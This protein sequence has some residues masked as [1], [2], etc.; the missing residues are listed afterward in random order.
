MVKHRFTLFCG[1]LVALLLLPVF[2]FAE[3][4]GFRDVEWGRDFSTFTDLQHLEPLPFSSVI[5]KYIK[6]GPGVKIGDITA[7]NKM[8]GFCQGKL[9][10]FAVMVVGKKDFLAL[11]N[12][13]FEKFGSGDQRVRH[14]E[15]YIR[16]VWPRVT[17]TSIELDYDELSW[18]GYLRMF[19]KKIYAQQKIDEQQEKAAVLARK[20]HEPLQS[21]KASWTLIVPATTTTP[22]TNDRSSIAVPLKSSK[23]CN[24]RFRIEQLH[25]AQDYRDREKIARSLM[26]Q[27]TFTTLDITL[28]KLFPG[29]GLE[30]EIVIQI[31][32]DNRKRF[33]FGNAIDVDA[34][35]RQGY[36]IVGQFKADDMPFPK[37]WQHVELACE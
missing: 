14:E 22:P 8:Y 5:K 26:G 24:E 23:L 36:R 2:V 37:F 33:T 30:P 7:E 34:W 12:A 28:R 15:N 17:T 9:C 1:L 13:T 10:Y 19:S 18:G 25:F 31:E 3:T 16:Y 11:K 27:G 21:V 20:S 29:R 32:N 4:D 35:P 6:I